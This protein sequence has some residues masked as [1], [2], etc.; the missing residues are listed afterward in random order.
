M[1]KDPKT[2]RENN[3][4]YFIYYAIKSR[5]QNPK[6]ACFANYGG[7]GITVEWQNF[8]EF[9]GDMGPR[10]SPKHTIERIDNTG[11]YSKE[12][13]R[14]ATRTEQAHN[15][16]NNRNITRN[17]KTQTLTEWARE[18][19]VSRDTIRARIKRG[20]PIDKLFIPRKHQSV[21]P[22]HMNPHDPRCPRRASDL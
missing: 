13:C 14:W 18:T 2:H 10:P 16:R 20:C 7:R 5:C 11:P 21:A 12:N 9:Y 3:R 8:K 15:K 19:G 17:G 4:E 1:R 22:R 6:A